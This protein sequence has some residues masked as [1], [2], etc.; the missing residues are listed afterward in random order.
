MTA[1]ESQLQIGLHFDLQLLNFF[2]NLYI[3]QVSSM[4]V[5]KGTKTLIKE[6]KRIESK[7]NYR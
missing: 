7:C 6:P 5:N 2:A 3:I 1:I 4:H